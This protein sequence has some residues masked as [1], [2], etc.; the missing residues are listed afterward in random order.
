[1]HALIPGY[2]LGLHGELRID[3]FRDVVL[4]RNWAISFEATITAG[5]NLG[6]A[7]IRLGDKLSDGCGTK[8][9]DPDCV[10]TP[11][12]NP[13]WPLGHWMFQFGISLGRRGGH[14]PYDRAEVFAPMGG[15]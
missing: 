9:E 8:E 14:P 11:D 5:L 13:T 15:S 12:G 4:D 2:T 10:R 1:M 7:A 6:K 3:W